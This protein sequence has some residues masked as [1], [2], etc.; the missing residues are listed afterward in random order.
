MKFANAAIFAASTVSA[1]SIKRQSDFFY[2]VNDFTASWYAITP[3][4]CF[5]QVFQVFGR[6]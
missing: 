6:D 1:A 3:T 4:P 5:F 2:T